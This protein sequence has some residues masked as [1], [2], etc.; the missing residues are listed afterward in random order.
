MNDTQ[1]FDTLDQLMMPDLS[2]ALARSRTAITEILAAHRFA[3]DSLT[4]D[5]AGRVWFIVGANG[6]VAVRMGQLSEA[7]FLALYA[8]KLDGVLERDPQRTEALRGQL[9][10]YL[11]GHRERFDILIDWSQMTPF[12]AQVLRAAQDIPLGSLNTYG[13]LAKRLGK[14]SAARAVGRALGTNPMPIIIPCHRVV[15]SDGSLTGYIGGLHVKQY[16]L[17]MEGAVA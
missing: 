17:Q 14:P 10:D 13:E 7:E 1:L 4:W 6:L 16:L 8:D 12:Q 9:A 15:A 5:V 11:T 2:D 3:Y